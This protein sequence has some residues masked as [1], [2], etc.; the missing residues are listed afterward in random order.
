VLTTELPEL[1]L[2]KQFEITALMLLRSLMLLLVYKLYK[3]FTKPSTYQRQ[4]MTKS[5]LNCS[6]YKTLPTLIQ[7]E[8]LLDEQ[9]EI[10]A[11]MLLMSLMLLLVYKF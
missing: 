2:N 6:L 11:L 7:M 9:L 1:L 8:L 3:A 10:K 4:L 5:T